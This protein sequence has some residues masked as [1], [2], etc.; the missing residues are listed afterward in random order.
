MLNGPD[1]RRGLSRDLD[2]TGD[3]HSENLRRAAE[4]A[5]IL[6]DA[7]LLCICAFVAPWDPVRETARQIVG[8]DRFLSVSLSPPGETPP[9]ADL[10]L[11]LESTPVEESVARIVGLLGQRRIIE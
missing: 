1:L 9:R 6:N 11:T 3:D 4:V 8:A 5:R 2:F 7:G 10:T